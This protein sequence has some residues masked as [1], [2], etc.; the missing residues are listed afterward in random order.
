MAKCEWIEMSDA[1]DIA[2]SLIKKY[3]EK[4]GHVVLGKMKFVGMMNRKK[5]NENTKIWSLQSVPDPINS[6]FDVDLVAIILLDYW[7]SMDIKNQAL[8]VSCIMD[9]IISKDRM[10]VRG[11]DI[12]DSKMMIN[13]F[14]LDYEY[15]P[16]VP[17]IINNNFYWR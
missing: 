5:S 13:N 4:F 15:N 10:S 14:G 9:C 11:Y 2:K 8:V 16:D 17:D 7:S 1:L 12:H 3:P 6:F